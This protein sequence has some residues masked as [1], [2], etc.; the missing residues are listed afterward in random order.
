MCTL[1]VFNA[2][3]NIA[4]VGTVIGVILLFIPLC[5]WCRRQDK[6]DT[7][8]VRMMSTEKHSLGDINLTNRNQLAF[9]VECSAFPYE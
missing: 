2:L 4:V 8:K 7:V 5:V 9:T 3:Q 1:V 6:K